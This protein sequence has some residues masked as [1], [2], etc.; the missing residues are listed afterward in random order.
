MRL[1]TVPGDV[2][3]CALVFVQCGGRA[4]YPARSVCHSYYLK[5]ALFTFGCSAGRMSLEAPGG[6]PCRC[7]FVKVWCVERVQLS[8]INLIRSLAPSWQH[9][10]EFVARGWRSNCMVESFWFT[11]LNPGDGELASPEQ[12]DQCLWLFSL[13]LHRN[14]QNSFILSPSAIMLMPK[15]SKG[16]AARIPSSLSSSQCGMQPFSWNCWLS[17][18][19][20]PAGWGELLG[21]LAARGAHSWGC[22][23]SQRYVGSGWCP[24]CSR[25]FAL[26]NLVRSFNARTMSPLQTM[27]WISMLCTNEIFGFV[28]FASGAFFLLVS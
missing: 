24:A 8:V 19:H 26:L 18:P 22:K 12:S 28:V 6:S 13:C 11:A 14:Q 4:S 23:K 7:I 20:P 5:R 2:W 1:T 21:C 27:I 25:L 3:C 9:L 15:Y 17:L 16:K 10:Q